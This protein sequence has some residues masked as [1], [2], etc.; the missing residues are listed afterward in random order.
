MNKNQN[1]SNQK[2]KDNIKAGVITLAVHAAVLLLL[3]FLSLH[4]ATP[5]KDRL[6]DGVAVLIDQPEPEEPE[7]DSGFGAPAPEEGGD[8]T[9]Q[10]A[11]GDRPQEAAVVE[12]PAPLAPR[13]NEDASRKVAPK[14]KTNA[15]EDPLLTQQKEAAIAAQEAA[16]K[17]K[18]EEDAA[19]KK[20]EQEAI[21][22]AEEAARKRAAEEA[23]RKKAAEEEARRK[24]EEA[25]KAA[26]AGNRVAGAFGSKGNGNGAGTSGGTGGSNTGD[27]G[28]GGIDGYEGNRQVLSRALPNYPDGVLDEGKVVVSIDVDA[29]GKVV[30]ASVLSSQTS[31]AQLKNA[32]IAAAR[33]W[34]FSKGAGT[35]KGKIK[36]TFRHR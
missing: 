1:N 23:A 28:S 8:E 31:S 9:P 2:K 5:D 30:S 15:A 24:A 35:D 33:R 14:P 6:E 13:T 4:A 22:K 3:A 16:K 34:T 17:K 29:D 12:N 32:A 7:P 36:F 18:A 25:K 10:E 27:Q 21:R 11:G 20:A 26:A 19:R